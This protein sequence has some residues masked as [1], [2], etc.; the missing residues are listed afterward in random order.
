VTR[1]RP[2]SRSSP[3][4]ERRL[5]PL[6]ALVAASAGAVVLGGASAA[7]PIEVSVARDAGAVGGEPDAK[8][9]SISSRSSR[10]EDAA[11][12]CPH[13]RGTVCPWYSARSPF[14]T[15]IGTGAT[16]DPNSEVMVQRMA[17]SGDFT[18]AVK[19][20]SVPVYYARS[21]TKRYNVRMSGSGL[22]AYR[23]PIPPNAW[24]SA[25][26]PPDETDGAMMV[27]DRKTR[28]EYDFWEARKQGDGSWTARG[29]NR[30]RTI[31]DGIYDHGASAR[32]SGFALGAGLIRPEELKAGAIRHALVFSLPSQYV[33]GGGPVPPATESDGQ[34]GLEGAI[35]EGARVQL[36]Q[37]FDVKT[38]EHPWQRTIARAL[39]LY[40]MYLADRGGG[41]VGLVAQNPQSYRRNPY[42]W[43]DRNYVYL[44]TKLISFMRILKLPPQYRPAIALQPSRCGVIR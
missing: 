10:S 37:S 6:F 25:P 5:G 34:S 3:R 16:T 9:I 33:K 11:I 40:G 41:G 39:Q 13:R 19:R 22:T 21:G 44:P 36:A 30:I 4:R 43:G 23:V 42:P 32:G 17:E 14:N 38:L 12:A 31:S 18:V 2:R 20:W 26:F 35:P 24:P 7:S 1:M 29:V 15:K 27:V 8:G 28:C